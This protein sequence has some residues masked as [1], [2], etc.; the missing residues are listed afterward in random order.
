RQFHEV[1]RVAIE[2]AQEPG[3]LVTIGITPTHPETGYGYVQFDGSADEIHD[4]LRAD[5]ARTFAEKPD[6]AAAVPFLDWC[7][8]L[9]HGGM[10]I[11]RSDA[12]LAAV[13]AH[14]PV[15]YES[16]RSAAAVYCTDAAHEATVPAS[17]RSP[18]ITFDYGVM[19]RAE[20]AY[21]V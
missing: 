10:F 2:K 8:L 14:L 7:A 9:W 15:A 11:W 19:E 17:Q 16:Y 3:A 20:R 18:H 6:I 5:P 4:K 1:L 13:R 21:V 12:I